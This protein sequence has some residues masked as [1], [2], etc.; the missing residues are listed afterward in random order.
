M[1]DLPRSNWSDYDRSA[2]SP[3][4]D[5]FERSAKSVRL[6]PEARAAL[7]LARETMTPN[8]LI[9]AML[10]AE[11]DL[12]FFGG[13][14]CFVRAST[15]SDADA[16]DRTNDAIRI[17]ARMLHAKI[18]GEGANLG[19]TQRA[20]IEYALAGGA[21]NTDAIDNSGGVDCSDHEVKI[22]RAHV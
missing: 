11:V 19:M 22:G 20:R 9:K 6:S 5:I 17:D 4:G 21:L 8:E 2:L 13:I 1:F 16:N 7:G 3:G 15:E 10:R 18:I 14:G 12:L